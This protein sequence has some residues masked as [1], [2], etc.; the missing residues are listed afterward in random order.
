VQELDLVALI[1]D[2]RDERNGQI[3]RVGSISGQDGNRD[4]IQFH[5]I[6]SDTGHGSWLGP[7]FLEQIKRFEPPV[8]PP[9]LFY[10]HNIVDSSSALYLAIVGER[11]SLPDFYRHYKRLR[12]G[13]GDAYL[14]YT[15]RELFGTEFPL[16]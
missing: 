2:P 4:I 11:C 15:W 3:A 7:T 16:K 1:R 8:N 5:L 6:F 14:H 13:D 10:R 9:L 12:N